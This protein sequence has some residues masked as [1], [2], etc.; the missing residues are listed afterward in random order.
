MHTTTPPN[1]KAKLERWE[2][3]HLRQHCADLA[4]RVED[5]QLDLERETAMA[6][7]W[8]EQC[9]ALIK[10]LQESGLEVG[11]TPDGEPDVV[12]NRYSVQLESTPATATPDTDTLVRTV[13]MDDAAEQVRCQSCLN[14]GLVRLPYSREVV[15]C[16]DCTARP[17]STASATTDASVNPSGS[18]A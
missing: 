8:R 15:T 4:T 12:S 1:I 11:I 16:P 2:L 7:Y 3:V 14:R 10:D 17:S 9:Q 5:L 6:D 18:N 13:S